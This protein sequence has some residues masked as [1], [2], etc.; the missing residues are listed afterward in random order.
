MET[1]QC[2]LGTFCHVQGS[3][4][5]KG[6]CRGFFIPLNR[7]HSLPCSSLPSVFPSRRVIDQRHGKFFLAAE[8]YM[9]AILDDDLV[10]DCELE[11]G[12][13]RGLLKHTHES[14]YVLVPSDCQP[15]SLGSCCPCHP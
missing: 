14:E 9:G 3:S 12:D 7:N 5:L 4:E 15:P 6:G 10:T 13:R 2:N 11:Y 8:L 1:L